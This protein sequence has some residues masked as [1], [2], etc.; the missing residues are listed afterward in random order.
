MKYNLEV[1]V[2][3]LLSWLSA[4]PLNLSCYHH[5]F[6]KWMDVQCS[7]LP[8]QNPV[9]QCLNSK[10]T[11]AKIVTSIF[12]KLKASLWI[13]LEQKTAKSSLMNIFALWKTN[14]AFFCLSLR[15]SVH[16]FYKDNPSKSF[17]FL[18]SILNY[19]KNVPVSSLFRNW[20]ECYHH[21]QSLLLFFPP[22][23]IYKSIG[24][25]KVRV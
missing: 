11:L 12:C 22:L 2:D 4:R 19:R 3:T 20:K 6:F 23:F 17:R 16:I 21:S 8:H 13:T 5:I 9:L 7:G 10:S 18:S 15:S 24:S 25:D 1:L 14:T